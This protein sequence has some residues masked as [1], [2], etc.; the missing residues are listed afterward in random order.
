M[1]NAPPPVKLQ[2]HRVVVSVELYVLAAD[3]GSAR[4]LGKEHAHEEVG[5]DHTQT[6]VELITSLYGVPTERLDDMPFGGPEGDDRTMREV[7]TGVVPR[8][9]TRCRCG[10]RFGRGSHPC[11]GHAYLCGK[12]AKR[13]DI[14]AFANGLPSTGPTPGAYETFACDECWAQHNR[15]TRTGA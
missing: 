4:V 14:P 10:Y 6:R 12:P 1:S 2:L 3:E 11:H 15:G 7:L 9:E 5:Y 13:R 8:T